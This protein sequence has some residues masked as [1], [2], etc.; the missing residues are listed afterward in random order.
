M[1]GRLRHVRR[2]LGSTFEPRRVLDFGC[3]TGDTTHALSELFPRARVVGTD[4]STRVLDY[5]RS[6]V[7]APRVSFEALEPCLTDAQRF[8]LCYANGVVH[9]VADDLLHTTLALLFRSLRSGGYLTLFENNPWNPGTRLV[10]S[11]IAFDRGARLLSATRLRRFLIQAG[12]SVVGRAERRPQIQPAPI[13][14]TDLP[15][16]ARLVVPAVAAG[17][18]GHALD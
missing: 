11:R 2:R 18:P 1:T 13:H 12:F 9:H 4:S 14:A 7:S 16:P 10:M 15:M 3:G 6:L 17:K 8:D 5:A